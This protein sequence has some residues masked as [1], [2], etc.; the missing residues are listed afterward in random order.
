[1][2]TK[3]KVGGCKGRYHLPYFFT[4]SIDLTEN[5]IYC[6]ITFPLIK[7]V[8]KCNIAYV[9]IDHSGRGQKNMAKYLLRGPHTPCSVIV[10]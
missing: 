6:R 8:G 9:T 10:T 2:G 1:M 7:A 3:S 5:D 4:F